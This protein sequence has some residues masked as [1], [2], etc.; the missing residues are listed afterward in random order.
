MIF[1]E[2]D[3]RDVAVREVPLQVSSEGR[4]QTA[5]PQKRKVQD[6]SLLLWTSGI[7]GMIEDIA[8]EKHGEVLKKEGGEYTKH[9]NE[10]AND[11]S[12][13]L[14]KGMRT[15]AMNVL[16]DGGSVNEATKAALSEW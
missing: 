9:A 1:E 4:E 13:E 6:V 7:W 15:Q 5:V 3:S 2:I 14:L 16:R 10:K 8:Q 12:L 11:A